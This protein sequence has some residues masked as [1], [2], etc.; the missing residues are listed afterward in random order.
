M[1]R[2]AG[3]GSGVGF[4]PIHWLLQVRRDVHVWKETYLCGKR[5]THVKKDL[6]DQPT[7]DIANIGFKRD[8]HIGVKRDLRDGFAPFHWVLQ[9]RRDSY[10]WKETY[11]CEKKLTYVERDLVIYKETYKCGERAMHFGFKRDLHIGV[12]KDLWWICSIL[13]IDAGERR[14]VYVKR[15]VYMWKDTFICEKGHL[16]QRI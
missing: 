10:L 6:Y 8:L 4:A 3:Q 5:P 16:I 7:Y 9:V 1:L 12:K 14:R 11:I 15:D 13:F 2:C